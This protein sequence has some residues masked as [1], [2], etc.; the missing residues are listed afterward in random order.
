ML[1]ET[2]ESVDLL[3]MS[4]GAPTL[5]YRPRPAAHLEITSLL[6]PRRSVVMANSFLYNQRSTR[7]GEPLVQIVV[8]LFH[9]QMTFRVSIIHILLPLSNQFRSSTH[10]QNSSDCKVEVAEERIWS[11][12]KFLSVSPPSEFDFIPFLQADCT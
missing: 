5:S 12:S 2:G 8:K 10:L 3:I 9:G 6:M 11:A 7:K 1:Q 4:D